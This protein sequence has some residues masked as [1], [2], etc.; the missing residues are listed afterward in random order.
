MNDKNYFKK[1]IIVDFDDTL[2]KYEEGQTHNIEGATPNVELIN[3]L[4]G[5][6]DDG[7]NIEIYTARGHF[8][9]DS[10]SE[11]E[12]RHGSRI[13]DW[14]EKYGVK[15]HALNFNKPYGIIYIDDKAVRPNELHLLEGL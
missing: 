12:D 11:A 6:Y 10:R 1:L 8:S 14:L 3:K 4:N 2:A 7:Y 15:Y 5:L 13:R 9:C